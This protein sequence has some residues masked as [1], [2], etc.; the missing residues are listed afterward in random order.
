MVLNIF[1]NTHHRKLVS[2]LSVIIMMQSLQFSPNL[3]S[4]CG[5]MMMASTHGCRQGTL[6][7]ERTTGSWIR[8]PTT[9]VEGGGR[10]WRGVWTTAFE[11]KTG[12]LM[13][14]CLKEKVRGWQ[15]GRMRK[16]RWAFLLQSEMKRARLYLKVFVDRKTPPRCISYFHAMS[17]AW[18]RALRCLSRW[19]FKSLSS[20]IIFWHVSSLQTR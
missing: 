3:T 10:L 8:L 9:V 12:S 4:R 1:S 14:T 2:S 20:H 15:K 11:S 17:H 7:W 13:R 5:R 16:M 18:V 6:K 19:L